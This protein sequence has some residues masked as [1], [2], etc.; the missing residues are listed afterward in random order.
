MKC[1]SMPAEPSFDRKHD[2]RLVA[3]GPRVW[4][5]AIAACKKQEIGGRRQKGNCEKKLPVQHEV[6]VVRAKIHC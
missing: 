5:M 2:G 6:R 4:A 3:G 1:F